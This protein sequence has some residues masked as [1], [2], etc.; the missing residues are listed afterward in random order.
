MC[1]GAC[2]YFSLQF[3]PT[4]AQVLVTGGVVAALAGLAL[5]RLDLPHTARMA[6]AFI[7][8]MGCALIVSKIHTDLR[9]APMVT[10]TIGPTMV[11]GWVNDVEPGQNGLRLRID[12]HAVAGERTQN[13]PRHI[14]LTHMS[15]LQVSP[16][17]FVRCWAVLRP[18]PQPALP[19]DYPFNR[20]AYFEGLD[21]VGYVQ[22]RCRGGAAGVQQRYIS[23]LKTG[24]GEVRRDL[25][26]H[27]NDIAGK[28]AGGF[29][30]ALTSG[31]RS[32]MRQADMEALRHSGLAHLLAISGLHLGIV[33]T[34][35]FFAFKRGLS[36]WEWLALRVP[37][38]K[39]AAA[40]ALLATGTYMLLSGAS[41][42]TQRA[43]I[44]AAVVFT[45]ILLDRS[46]LSL[47]SFAIAMIAVIL[48]QP[49]SVM[50]PGFQMSFAA[51]G[52]LI[53]TYEAWNRKKAEEGEAGRRG[54]GFVMKSLVVTSIVGAAATAPF[55]LYHFDRVA[56]LGL[57]AN[58]LAMPIITFISAPI[59]GLAL[60]SWPFGLSDMFLRIFGWSLARVL[61]VAHWAADAGQSGLRMGE[62]MP[63][64][65][66]VVLC[67]GL[68][69]VCLGLGVRQRLGAATGGMAASV[70]LWTASPD[71][72]VHW[73]AS[74][75]VY[76]NK[77]ENVK[78]L[79]FADGD[80]LGPLQ[81]ADIGTDGNCREQGCRFE[82]V[83][84]AIL[85]GPDTW[86]SERCDDTVLAIL[87]DKPV[88]KGCY[89]DGVQIA[90]RDVQI[91]GGITL[92]RK[93]TGDLDRYTPTCGR[94]P[95]TP[96]LQRDWD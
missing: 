76:L 51:T 81:F 85:I 88:Q 28:R 91:A 80:G 21:A 64:G 41:I 12:V 10:R 25:A 79:S 58:L 93:M 57:I 26:R 11:E 24:L 70:L 31:D 22:G 5:F 89:P 40:A 63:T 37:T 20:Q 61:D 86:L 39:P 35:V 78:R 92:I 83:S 32:Y 60:V 15:E 42:S 59:A 4:L 73:S 45:A 74:G 56:P 6:L 90:W 9:P 65:V 48:L 27:V 69:A 13:L 23:R 52:A 17:R 72:L 7:S 38:Q 77:G 54:I 82:T 2:I 29:A 50:T 44:M 30:A 36:A 34:L 67:V 8:A 94:R 46:P 66:L 16:G 3:E 96:C 84:G 68:V 49:A 19:G 87:T 75:D 1:A 14:R 33:G 18:P 47:R 43:F 71:M 62:Q 95:W 53:V 55:A